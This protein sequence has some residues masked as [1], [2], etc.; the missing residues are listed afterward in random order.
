MDPSEADDWI[1]AG[2]TEIDLDA[3]LK[4]YQDVGQAGHD[5]A[6]YVWLI[7]IPNVYGGTDRIDWSARA[8]GL[9]H[10]TDITVS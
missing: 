3:R 1:D 5:G 6:W 10:V 8:D 9:I 4:L 2:R 7:S